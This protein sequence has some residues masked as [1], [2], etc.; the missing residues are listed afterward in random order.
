MKYVKINT[1]WKRDKR[2]KI[3][4]CEYSKAE[5]PNIKMWHL[6]EKIH[7]TNSRVTFERKNKQEKLLFGGKTDDAQISVHL[8]YHLQDTFKIEDFK[9]IW[10]GTEDTEIILF[11]EGYGARIQKGGGRYRDDASFILFD[12]WIDGWWLEPHNVKDIA[13]KLKIDYVPE[14]GIMTEEEA[15]SIV[16]NQQPIS[17]ISQDRTLVAEG[18][19]ARAYPMVLFRDGTPAMWKLKVRDFKEDKC[20]EINEKN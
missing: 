14:L 11:G 5:I 7:G 16:E 4:P 2:G 13:H 20:S 8:L 3:I 12:V 18:I 1:I 17:K 19:V 6:S 15:I 9:R 10:D